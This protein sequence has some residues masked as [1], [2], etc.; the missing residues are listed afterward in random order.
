MPVMLR[1]DKI[2]ISIKHGVEKYYYKSHVLRNPSIVSI[3]NKPL[4]FYSIKAEINLI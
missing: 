1:D 3:Y 2:F 4:Y